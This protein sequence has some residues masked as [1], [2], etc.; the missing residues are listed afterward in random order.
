[1][2]D[3]IPTL[4]ERLRG[5]FKWGLL[6]DIQPPDMETRLAILRNKAEREASPVG[7]DV[8]EFIATHIT[9]N[10]RELEGALI[11]V[12][13][14][15]S[16]N[17]VPV[18]VVKAE[19][20]LADL[21]TEN[22]PKV[23]TDQEMLEEI[24]GLLGYPVEQLCGKSRQRPLVTARQIAMYVFRQITDLSYPS[25]AKLFGGRDHTTVI[26]AVDKI[27]RLMKERKQIFDQ[28][29]DLTQRLKMA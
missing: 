23:R 7:S 21:L 17:Q 27:E 6:T 24:A 19:H 4:E 18:T 14:Y 8:L 2:P 5:R 9:S 22:T 25:I 28:V 13:A 10:I 16:L 1:V 12:S 20:L 11:R 3:A 29:N 26:H 15:A